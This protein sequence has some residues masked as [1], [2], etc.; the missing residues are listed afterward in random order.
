M[1]EATRRLLTGSASLGLAAASC[2]AHSGA[3]FD[4]CAAGLDVAP[5]PCQAVLIPLRPGKKPASALPDRAPSNA[6][7]GNWA[8]KAMSSALPLATGIAGAHSFVNPGRC[9]GT[10]PSSPQRRRRA[11]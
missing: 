3:P 8:G 9:R 2:L 7:S 6:T 1:I 5:A 10:Q 11:A 4:G